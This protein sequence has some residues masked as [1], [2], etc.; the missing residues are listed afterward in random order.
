MLS[1]AIQFAEGL[2]FAHRHGV[3][4]QDVK[5]GNVLIDVSVEST[6]VAAGIAFW[7]GKR[8]SAALVPS[9]LD[10]P[11]RL[12]PFRLTELTLR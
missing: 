2:G 1:F 5:P 8:E 11:R 9:K 6:G 4:D 10:H 3:I 12:I 7:T